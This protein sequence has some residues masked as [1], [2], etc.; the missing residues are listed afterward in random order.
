M[1]VEIKEVLS[2]SD[3]MKFIRFPYT[4]FKNNPYWVPALDMDEKVSFSDDK[5]PA[6]EFCE[7]EDRLSQM[8]Y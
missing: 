4:I 5:N 2:K 1:N 7:A 6:F 8:V 3:L